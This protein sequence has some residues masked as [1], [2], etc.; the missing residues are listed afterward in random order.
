MKNL[1]VGIVEAVAGRGVFYVPI[2]VINGPVFVAI[3]GGEKVRK[4]K[5]RKKKKKR[6]QA[7]VTALEKQELKEREKLTFSQPRFFQ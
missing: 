3:M 7:K 5:E 1:A 6:G 4:K 2:R